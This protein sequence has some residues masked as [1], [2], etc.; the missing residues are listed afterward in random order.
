HVEMVRAE[1]LERLLGSATDD[2]N[3]RARFARVRV[4]TNVLPVDEVRPRIALSH[5]DRS[6]AGTPITWSALAAA[7]HERLPPQVTRSTYMHLGTIAKAVGAFF[8]LGMSL[9]FT[10]FTTRQVLVDAPDEAYL[11]LAPLA[12]ALHTAMQ[13][14]QP[15]SIIPAREGGG[16]GAACEWFVMLDPDPRAV[17]LDVTLTY[18]AQRNHQRYAPPKSCVLEA[19]ASIELG[20][21]DELDARTAQLFGLRTRT[22]GQLAIPR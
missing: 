7:T 4:Q 9:P 21:V 16:V 17:Q 6:R 5:A 1:H 10:T 14:S 2:V 8:T 15:C 18:V 20:R 12:H 22:L 13:R 19:T 11:A 3:R